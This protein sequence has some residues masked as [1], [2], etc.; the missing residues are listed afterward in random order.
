MAG[1]LA[2]LPP[3]YLWKLLG[4][5]SP[6]PRRFLF[7]VGYSTGARTRI[8][9]TSLKRNV[10]FVSNHLSW[11][12]I[13]VIAGASGSAFVSKD[14]VGR[15]PVIGWLARLNNTVFI[16]RTER[17]AVRGQADALRSALTSGQPVALFPE[18]T[19]AGGSEVLPFRASLLASLFPPLAGIKVQ[20]VAIHYGA[21]TEEIAWVGEEPAKANA[22]RV[23]SRK[24][25][26]PVT[27]RFLEPID[28]ADTPDRKALAQRSRAAIVEALTGSGRGP[29]RL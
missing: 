11:L 21:A 15:W 7:W 23:F 14:E 10:L 20:P 27:V 28:P 24:G 13:M 1:L 4:R 25:K 6:W 9:G 8:V 18:G 19:T 17:S 2:C 16:A 3:H 22:K 5:R 12:D 26:L 29:D